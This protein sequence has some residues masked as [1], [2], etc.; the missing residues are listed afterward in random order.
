[1][2]IHGI[3]YCY[4]HILNIIRD[5]FV[6]V[7]YGYQWFGPNSFEIAHHT[8]AKIGSGVALFVI[9]YVVMR[10]LPNHRPDRRSLSYWLPDLSRSYSI[11]S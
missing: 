6:I 2:C 11:K 5:V 3:L 8:I 1:M 9:A 10:I 4:I 7:A